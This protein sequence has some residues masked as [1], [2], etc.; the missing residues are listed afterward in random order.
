MLSGRYTYAA[1][2]LGLTLI[3]TGIV[4]MLMAALDYRSMI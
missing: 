3:G 1:R 2:D 4:A